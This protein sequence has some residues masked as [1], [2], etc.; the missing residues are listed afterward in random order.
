MMT[1][2]VSATPALAISTAVLVHLFLKR[3]R[4]QDPIEVVHTSEAPAGT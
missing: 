2:L 4:F 3:K 1:H